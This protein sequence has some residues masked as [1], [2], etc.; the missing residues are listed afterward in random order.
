MVE[1]LCSIFSH[2][3][4]VIFRPTMPYRGNFTPELFVSCI[5]VIMMCSSF[6]V[7]YRFA[8]TSVF[9]VNLRLIPE[10]SFMTASLSF[11]NSFEL[12]LD[13]KWN[14]WKKVS[15]IFYVC[16]S[17]TSKYESIFEDSF[18]SICFFFLISFSLYKKQVDKND[19][20]IF[21]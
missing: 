9:S 15:I 8:F 13:C 16:N 5:E 10:F 18:S 3:K 14:C 4:P 7:K 17:L 1:N 19:C 21:F 20:F 12:N 6:L 11:N 2:I